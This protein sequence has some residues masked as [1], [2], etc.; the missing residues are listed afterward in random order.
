MK[1]MLCAILVCLMAGTGQAKDRGTISNKVRKDTQAR[2]YYV[3]SEEPNENRASGTAVAI[4]PHYLVT[5]RHV[6][7]SSQDSQKLKPITRIRIGD[8]FINATVVKD[9]QNFDLVLLRTSASL[10]I[11]SKN[12]TLQEHVVETENVFCCRIEN[13]CDGHDKC[14]QRIFIATG[15]V[16][17][18]I[19]GKIFTDVMICHGDSGAALFNEKGEWIGIQAQDHFDNSFVGIAIPAYKINKFLEGVRL[20]E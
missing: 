13:W 11:P 15:R 2:C 18:I 6:L 5:C 12:I 8:T 1:R 4:R 9:S 3:Q 19:Q 17:A 10:P 16:V 7:E 20:K 14:T